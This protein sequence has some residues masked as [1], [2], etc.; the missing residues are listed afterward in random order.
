MRFAVL[1]F[2]ATFLLAGCAQSQPPQA[3]PTTSSTPSVQPTAAATPSQSPTA[4][5]IEEAIRERLS[6]TPSPGGQDSIEQAI[7]AKLG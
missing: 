1:L 7:R 5:A 4:D 6:A 2:F 3:T